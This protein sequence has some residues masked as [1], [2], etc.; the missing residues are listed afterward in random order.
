LVCFVARR[1]G[2]PIFGHYVDRI[3]RKAALTATALL[4]W[5]GSGV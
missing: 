1:I 5:S 3:G 4:A 2:T